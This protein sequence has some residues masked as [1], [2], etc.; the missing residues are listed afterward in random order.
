MTDS[1]NEF[2]VTVED[3]G[4]F[5]FAKRDMR[6]EFRI[7]AEYGR[8]TEGISPVPEHTDVLATA[9]AA[10]KVL[11]LKA[12]DGWDIDSMDPLDQ[13]TYT[14]L[15]AVF[16]ALR[17]REAA[18]RARPATGSEAAREGTEPDA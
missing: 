2:T 9:V 15:L 1:P 3:V 6:R 7:H 8:L 10:L 18:F 13:V 14:R 5:T 11:T 16:G 4:A 12:P 17:A